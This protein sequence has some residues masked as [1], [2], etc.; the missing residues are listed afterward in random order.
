MPLGVTCRAL[1]LEN[2]AITEAIKNLILGLKMRVSSAFNRSD[3][4][5]TGDARYLFHFSLIT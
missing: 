2:H 4:R 5:S 3:A 1:K